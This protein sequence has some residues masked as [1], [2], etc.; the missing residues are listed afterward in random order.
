MT[1]YLTERFTLQN[2]RDVIK[3][4]AR[5]TLNTINDELDNLL[6]IC[7]NLASLYIGFTPD[8]LSGVIQTHTSV[9][10]IAVV[11]VTDTPEISHIQSISH[12]LAIMFFLIGIIDTDNNR[13]VDVQDGILQIIARSFN[14]AQKLQRKTSIQSFGGLKRDNKGTFT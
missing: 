1:I 3:A 4:A 11:T 14:D 2:R 8:V 7:D 6:N 12:Q 13:N 10:D 5:V 9:G